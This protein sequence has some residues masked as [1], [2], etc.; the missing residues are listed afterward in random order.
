MATTKKSQTLPKVESVLKK[1]PMPVVEV[2]AKKVVLVSQKL[3]EKS[4]PVEENQQKQSTE[5]EVDG[6]AEDVIGPSNQT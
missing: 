5:M 3:E 2:P 6:V 1:D 4:T